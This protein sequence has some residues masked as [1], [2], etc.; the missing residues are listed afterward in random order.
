[1]NKEPTAELIRLLEEHEKS[2]GALYE[3]FASLF[4]DFQKEWLDFAEEENLHAGWINKLHTHQQHG[5][6]AFQQTR[7]TIE[8]IKTAINFLEKQKNRVLAEQPDLAKCLDLSINI[9][10]SL[11][12]SS[13]FKVFH[14]TAPETQKI[15][16]KLEKATRIHINQLVQW[17]A[18]MR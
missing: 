2:I 6:I 8:S 11:L 10:K 17:R 3:A 4:P 16:S 1:M 15:Q 7:I 5:K 12:E 9:E 18:G 14:L 13:F